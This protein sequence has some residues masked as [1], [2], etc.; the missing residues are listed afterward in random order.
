MVNHCQSSATVLFTLISIKILAHTSRKNRD[1]KQTRKDLR[2]QSLF[3][4]DGHLHADD[5]LS[6]KFISEQSF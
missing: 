1:A 2:N 3:K 4:K 5:I 6:L